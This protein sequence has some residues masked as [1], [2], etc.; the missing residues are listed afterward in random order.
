MTG[1]RRLFVALSGLGLSV[2]LSLLCYLFVDRPLARLCD[3]LPAVTHAVFRYLSLL[4][5]FPVALA[6][7]LIM[8]TLFVIR[9]YGRKMSQVSQAPLLF[10]PAATLTTWFFTSALKHVFGRYRPVM[11]LTRELYGFRF[12]Q[13][14]YTSTSFPSGHAAIAFSLLLAAAVVRPKD[15]VALIALAAALALSRVVIT[16]HFLGDVIAGAA[17]GAGFVLLFHTIFEHRGYF[18]TQRSEND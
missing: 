8:L 1:K 14:G 13:V 4:S 16:A 7:C 5:S 18:V 17:V 10:V 9:V 6:L 2:A 15:R 12:L 11:L 3:T